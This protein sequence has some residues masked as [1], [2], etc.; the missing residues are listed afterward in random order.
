MMAPRTLPI[1]IKLELIKDSEQGDSTAVLA[2]RYKVHPN[3]VLRILKNKNQWKEAANKNVSEIENNEHRIVDNR[4][5]NNLETNHIRIKDINNLSV[6]YANHQDQTHQR[7]KKMSFR[8]KKSNSISKSKSTLNDLHQN[9]PHSELNASHLTT[10]VFQ[11]HVEQ[12]H[13]SNNDITMM[14]MM[15][16]SSADYQ[17]SC[18][19]LTK[20][21]NCRRRNANTVIEETRVLNDHDFSLHREQEMILAFRK[22]FRYID[23]IE[24]LALEFDPE[25]TEAFKF[26]RNL[27]RS[28][29]RYRYLLY[30]LEKQYRQRSIALTS[31]NSYRCN[32][33][34]ENVA[35]EFCKLIQTGISMAS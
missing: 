11:K 20:L 4:K 26:T 17:S 28:S 30:E 27:N 24:E 32:R 9:D 16:N 19:T 13:N 23:R 7:T 10:K 6:S 29:L 25:F 18:A 3:T 35:M 15:R 2:D 31:A 21:S 14:L 1:Q 34:D 12:A 22:F 8:K 5:E 33:S